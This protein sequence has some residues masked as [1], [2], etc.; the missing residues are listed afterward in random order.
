[1][2]LKLL[3]PLRRGLL[4]SKAN[5]GEFLGKILGHEV[6]DLLALGRAAGVLDPRVNILRIFAVDDHID[7][8]GALH[9]AGNAAK[10]AHGTEADVEIEHLPQ[11]DVQG[12]NPPADRR[13][14]RSLDPHEKSPERL[15]GVIRQPGIELLEAL[16]AGENFHPGDLSFPAIGHFNGRIEDT[17][18]GPPDIRAG[19]VA[20][21]EWDDG[22]IGH[23][24]FAAG[25]G[26]RLSARGGVTSLN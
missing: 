18:A 15:D 14:Q 7:L 3:E 10:I 17:L 24:Q 8:L 25:N 2:A 13:R 19:A 1:M 11:G 4:G 9:R 21:D 16:S 20:F 5:L 6:Q 22:M 23:D 12:A 26:N